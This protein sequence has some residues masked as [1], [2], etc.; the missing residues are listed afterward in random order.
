MSASNWIFT[1]LGSALVGLLAWLFQRAV[2]GI[3]KK[4]EDT[5]TQMT[6][7]AVAVQEMRVEMTGYNQLVKYLS[8]DVK[9][10]K[11]ENRVLRDSHHTFD[12][13]IAVQQALHKISP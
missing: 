10:L 9:E 4:V 6:K 3:D 1:L 11:Q 13:F 7:T 12:K 8:E 5:C 2:A